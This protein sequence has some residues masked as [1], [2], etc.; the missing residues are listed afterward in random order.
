FLYHWQSKDPLSTYLIAMAG[1]IN[2]DLDI[3]HWHPLT[4]PEDSIPVS[5]YYASAEDPGAAK[6]HTLAMM[7]YFSNLYGDYPFEKY[8]TASSIDFYSEGM[9]NQSISI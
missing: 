9:E 5:F 3:L 7:D 2:F 4:H 6:E 1:K 8:G